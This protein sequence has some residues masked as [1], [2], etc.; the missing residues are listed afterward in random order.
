MQETEIKLLRAMRE[1]S[2]NKAPTCGNGIKEAARLV[3]KCKDWSM[4]PFGK[5]TNDYQSLL[6]YLA[7]NILAGTS[8]CCLLHFILWAT[9][10]ITLIHLIDKWIIN[11]IDP[12]NR[13]LQE[14]H[15]S[16]KFTQKIGGR[17]AFPVSLQ[18]LSLLCFTKE[19]I[20]FTLK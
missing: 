12:F 8:I 14:L 3:Q 6:P 11:Y 15:Y 20:I 17:M 18:I 16:P 9:E 1:K 10:I 2:G 4:E 19:T 5:K 7:P 13:G